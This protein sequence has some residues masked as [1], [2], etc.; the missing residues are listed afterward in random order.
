MKK[1]FLAVMAASILMVAC[2]SSSGS[3][4]S[5]DGTTA[6]CHAVDAPVMKFEK[7]NAMILVR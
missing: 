7:R 3:T 2:N 1:L 5:T 6:N 4:A